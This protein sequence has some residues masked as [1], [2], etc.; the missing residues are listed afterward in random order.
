MLATEIEQKQAVRV[1]WLIQQMESLWIL[2]VVMTPLFVNLWVEQQFEASKV[3]LVR[4]L[5]LILVALWAAAVFYGFR[6]KSPHATIIY[7][8][9][10]L[11]FFIILSS[12]FSDY[13]W[14]ATFGSLERANGSITQLCYLAL[15]LC[16][17]TTI[18][19]DSAA[20]LLRVML[21]TSLPIAAYALI[22]AA[23]WQPFSLLTDGR[24]TLTST[25]GRSN[26]TGAYLAMLLPLA[27]AG[28]DSAETTQSRYAYSVLILL[29]IAVITLSGARAA[30][31]SALVG[32]GLY[33][34]LRHAGNWSARMRMVSLV[35]G[36][37]IIALLLFGLLRW[38][39]N[40]GGS[41]AARWTIWRAT[42]GL[43]WP[44]LFLGHGADTL[45]L[46]F[47][48][49]YPPELVYYQ[50]RTAVVD[51]AHNWLLDWTF[52]HGFFATLT[53]IAL[54]LLIGWRAWQSLLSSEQHAV[55]T[56]PYIAGSLT[57]V[58]AYL[59]GSLFLFE[60]ASTAVLFWVILAILVAKPTGFELATPVKFRPLLPLIVLMTSAG[61]WHASLRPLVGDMFAW[62]GTQQLSASP[63]QA[64]GHYL[65]AIAW[66]PGRYEY[67]VAAG[68]VSA[69]IG[70]MSQAEQYLLSALNMRP[71]D[72]ALYTQLALLYAKDGAAKANVYAAFERAI[73]LAP[74]LAQTYQQYG[75]TALLNGDFP[76]A[77]EQAGNAVN[78]DATDANSFSILGWAQLQIGN[79]EA[80]MR[81]FLEAI[82]W[83]P[84]SA[85]SHLGLATAYIELNQ[86]TEAMLAISTVLS[87][88][89]TNAIALALQQQIQLNE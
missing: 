59:I 32:I 35:G 25:L 29:Q 22:Q 61:I 11:A 43:I 14:I 83:E 42:V 62:R 26:F 58:T 79:P 85:D 63:E 2:L 82:R 49:I 38:G 50:G 30:W 45:E 5:V 31:L 10:T 54:L 24:T 46:Y 8:V 76:R 16:I 60:V 66:Q 44:R 7:T 6:P 73:T 36:S 74:T 70:N 23:G 34:W 81:A 56:K 68:L 19:Q 12:A 40:A 75:E 53:L 47:P 41:I 67:R 72:P 80:A 69:E 39:I 57:S 88:E 3:W 86:P 89:P 13:K 52:T 18:T 1:A 37:S 21:W 78:L 64:V 4:A 48:A 51:R 17:A 77:A 33:F 65:T 87:L 84:N 71:H 55:I 28:W 27:L 9:L 15:F 20:R